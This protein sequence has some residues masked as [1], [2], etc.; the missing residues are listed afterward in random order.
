MGKTGKSKALFSATEV[1]RFCEVDIKT[2]HNWAEQG[3]IP[4]F[5]T[6]GRHLRFHRNDVLEFLQ[7][8][9]YPMPTVLHSGKPK[10]ISI[11]PIA[12]PHTSMANILDGFDTTEYVDAIDALIDM[13]NDPPDAAVVSDELTGVDCI[14]FIKQLKGHKITRRVRVVVYYSKA[15]M[16]RKKDALAAGASARVMQGETEE[17]RQTLEALTKLKPA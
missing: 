11:D 15:R 9:G 6:P 14:H 13:G 7:R 12:L 4:H 8:Y 2:I 16:Y 1:A 17:L 3:E 5:R 10:V